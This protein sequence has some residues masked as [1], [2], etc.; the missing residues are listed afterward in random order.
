MRKKFQLVYGSSTKRRKFYNGKMLKKQKESIKA[1]NEFFFMR[2]GK[3]F[4]QKQEVLFLQGTFYYEKE[5][6]FWKTKLFYEKE[7]P[8][9]IWEFH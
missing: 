8:V 6:W 2:K 5:I 3:E 7:V 9:S 1:K 4:C